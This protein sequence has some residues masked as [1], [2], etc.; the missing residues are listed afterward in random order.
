MKAS[1]E[2]V[3]KILEEEGITISKN[4]VL[5][6]VNSIK[7]ISAIV[8]IEEEFNIEFPDEYLTLDI[9]GNLDNIIK[10]LDELII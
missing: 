9:M 10:I 3:E 2:K 8:N 4:G 1:K 6:D 5:Q 7:F